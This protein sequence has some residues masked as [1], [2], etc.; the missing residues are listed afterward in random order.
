[1]SPGPQNVI[2]A[3]QIVDA[4]A[5]VAGVV[6]TELDDGETID[7]PAHTKVIEGAFSVTIVVLAN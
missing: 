3:G 6:S 7:I 2:L 5:E 4:L 1:M